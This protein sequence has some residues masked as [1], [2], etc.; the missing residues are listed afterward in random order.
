M[1]QG[2]LIERDVS[3]FPMYQ[4]PEEEFL[5]LWGNFMQRTNHFY[6]RKFWCQIA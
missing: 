4:D 2:K 1:R 6:R 5:T 3:L